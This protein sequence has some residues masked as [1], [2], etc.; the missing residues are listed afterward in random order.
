MQPGFFFDTRSGIIK[1][2]RESGT[3]EE[4][5]SLSRS[6][7]TPPRLLICYSSYDCPAHVKAVMQLGAFIQQHMGTQVVDMTFST[8]VYIEQLQFYKDH[9]CKSLP[10]C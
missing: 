10:M 4:V 7:L 9:F 6:K 1:Q 8:A 3:K 2:H 5:V